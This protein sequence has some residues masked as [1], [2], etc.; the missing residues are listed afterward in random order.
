MSETP[1]VVKKI[2]QHGANDLVFQ[3]QEGSMS[4]ARY[5]TQKRNQPLKFPDNL[6]VEVGAGA[7]IPIELCEVIP[8]QI[9]RKQIP[10]SVPLALLRICD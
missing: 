4:V 5:F 1:R 8:G 7:L 10:V 6:C 3:T 9:M 2:T